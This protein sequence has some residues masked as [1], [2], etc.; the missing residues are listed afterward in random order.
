MWNYG[1]LKL[2]LPTPGGGGSQPYKA[3]R[4]CKTTVLQD[5]QQ[6][7]IL[8]IVYRHPTAAFYGVHDYTPVLRHKTGYSMRSIC[9]KQMN[10]S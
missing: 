10:K 4:N 8:S 3:F 7:P 5:R 1:K 9:S 2:V 6:A